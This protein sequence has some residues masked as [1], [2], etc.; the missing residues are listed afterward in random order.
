MISNDF[1]M[2][3]LRAIVTALQTQEIPLI[4]GGGYGLFL[5][6]EYIRQRRI[7]TRLSPPPPA[8]ATADIDIFLGTEVISD[9]SKTTEIRE[10]LNRLGY[11]PVDTAKFY[12]FYKNIEY[13]GSN[14]AIKF[15]FLAA[16]VKGEY[17]AKVKIDKRRIRPRSGEGFHAHTTPEAL[18]KNYGKYHAFDVYTTWAM[19]TEGEWGEAIKICT[20]YAK[21]SQVIKAKEIVNRLF[22]SHLAIGVIRIKEH[23]RDVSI[24][25]DE[26]TTAEF[27]ADLKEIISG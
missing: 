13:S 9:E 8:R 3:E 7:R 19:M 20:R 26:S 5:K 27:L 22:N 25:F 14:R 11:L 15:D 2:N 17:A 10:A 24:E 16:P 12:Q 6:A 23:A 18:T 1:L 21:D 4:I